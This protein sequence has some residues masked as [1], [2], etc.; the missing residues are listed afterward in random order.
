MRPENFYCLLQILTSNSLDWMKGSESPR[1]R[2][3]LRGTGDRCELIFSDNGPG[4]PFELAGENLRAPVQSQGRWPGD[5]ADHRE[6]DGRG[7]WRA[8]RPDH[9]RP[10]E[11][12]E[13]PRHAFQ[14]AF[15]GNG[16]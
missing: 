9:R 10:Q 16:L 4:V 1:I 6:A 3:T 13:F 15:T 14:K 12:S 2:L 7:A 11:G 8:D 5:G